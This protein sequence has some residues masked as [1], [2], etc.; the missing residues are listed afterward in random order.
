MKWLR[1][2]AWA[3]SIL[4]AVY[5]GSLL[6]QRV[7]GEQ[8]HVYARAVTCRDFTAQAVAQRYFEGNRDEARGLDADSDGLACES[9][10]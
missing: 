3:V 5:A 6:V 4:V 10:P 7:G 9:L 2:L 8:G 1:A